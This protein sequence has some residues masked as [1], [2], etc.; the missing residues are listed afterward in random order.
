MRSAA[1]WI[2]PPT[3]LDRGGR[4]LPAAAPCGSYLQWY[5]AADAAAFD[6]ATVQRYRVPLLEAGLALDHQPEAVRHP[7]PGQRGR[8]QRPA[9]PAARCGRG[10]GQGRGLGR[11]PHRQLA[12]P[13]RRLLDAPDPSTRKAPSIAP[14]WPSCSAVVSVARRSPRSPW[15][16][17][18]SGIGRWVIVDLV[19]KHHRVRSV[20]MPNW[21]RAAIDAWTERAGTVDGHVFRSLRK[22]DGDSVGAGMSTQG[23]I[24]RP[25]VRPVLPKPPNGGGREGSG[26][27]FLITTDSSDDRCN[28]DPSWCMEEQHRPCGLAWS[29]GLQSGV[30][31]GSTATSTPRRL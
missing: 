8:R 4:R 12:E 23:V 1:C 13:G 25:I 24:S 2:R 3:G 19:G 14:S 6:R 11:H 22:G 5:K 29:A 17:S 20:P 7:R 31:R 21:T 9:R 10:Q 30:E 16:V 18:S 26:G 15:P 28:P 27:G